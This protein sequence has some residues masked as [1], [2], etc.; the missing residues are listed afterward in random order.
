MDNFFTKQKPEGFVPMDYSFRAELMA[1][2]PESQAEAVSFYQKA[3][4]ADTAAESKVELL[5]KAAALAKK[6]G[7]RDAEANFLKQLYSPEK[8]P[9]EC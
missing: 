5:N 2:F 8:E 1:K 9:F 7:Q 4:D 6:V 3:V